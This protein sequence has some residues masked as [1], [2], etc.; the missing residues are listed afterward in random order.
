MTLTK[1]TEYALRTLRH[2][3]HRE[4]AVFSA[5]LLHRELKIPKKYLQRLLTDLS[6]SRLLRSVRGRK[7]GFILA[8]STEQI[9]LAEIID[10]V[11]GFNAGERCFFGFERCVLDRPCAMHEVW[12]RTQNSLVLALS[13][14]RLSDLVDH[15]QPG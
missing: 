13:T 7:G 3:S 10:A 14:T 5:D 6:K 8:R 11:E 4:H 15:A 2:M 1:T 12:T 9:T